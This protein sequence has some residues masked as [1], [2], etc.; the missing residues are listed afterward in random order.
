MLLS[1]SNAYL[2]YLLLLWTVIFGKIPFTAVIMLD[3]L[4]ALIRLFLLD[5]YFL[6]ILLVSFTEPCQQAVHI[7]EFAKGQ[8]E[9]GQLS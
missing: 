2:S 3:I 6:Q 8:R 1:F 9:I 5:Y 7:A 4:C